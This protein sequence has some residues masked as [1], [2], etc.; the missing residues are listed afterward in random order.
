MGMM[1]NLFEKEEFQD[2]DDS[3]GDEMEEEINNNRQ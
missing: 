1:I 2:L 3:E